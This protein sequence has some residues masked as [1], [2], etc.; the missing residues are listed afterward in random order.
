[1]SLRRERTAIA[2]VAAAAAAAY[3]CMRCVAE[4]LVA[5]R[6]LVIRQHQGVHAAV[7]LAPAQPGGAAGTPLGPG[8]RQVPVLAAAGPTV[9]LGGP[10]TRPDSPARAQSGGR[11]CGAALQLCPH[12]AGGQPAH[13]SAGITLRV[14]FFIVG[15]ASLVRVREVGAG[16]EPLPCMAPT[17]RR[18]ACRLSFCGRESAAS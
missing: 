3:A 18:L 6:H 7:N 14:L 12:K 10:Q 2:Y 9:A 17:G 1:M 11:A 4:G 13:L 15:E 5:A 16:R 8:V